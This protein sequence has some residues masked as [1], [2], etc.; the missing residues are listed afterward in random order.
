M[1]QTASTAEGGDD[2]F[3]RNITWLSMDYTALYPRR[4]SSSSYL[5]F[6]KKGIWHN[7]TLN[8]TGFMHLKNL[9]LNA[10]WI[11]RNT[12]CAH[13]THCGDGIKQRNFTHTICH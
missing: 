5:L 8:I 7:F 9:D 10:T 2:M 1:K 3:L 4:Q 6:S 13:T 12:W 11:S